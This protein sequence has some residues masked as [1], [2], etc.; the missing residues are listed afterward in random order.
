M[1]P[2]LEE[3]QLAPLL[4]RFYG[5]VRGDALLGPVFEDAISDWPHHL[6]QI[7]DFWS[8]VMIS[9]SRYKGNP[10]ATHMRHASRITPPMFDRWLALWATTTSELLPG[11][12][13]G[14]LQEKAS[15]IAQSLRLGLQLHTPEGRAAMLGSRPPPASVTT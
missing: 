11:P 14:A 13:A 6:G 4:D 9:S 12:V 5:R 10:M 3:H 1:E 7:A 15:R 8:S 2:V